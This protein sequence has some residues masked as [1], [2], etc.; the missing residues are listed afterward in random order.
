MAKRIICRN[1]DGVQ[2]EFNYSFEPFFL[3]SV[4]GI[5]TVSNNVV[6]SENTM[7]DGSTY[8][9]S[10]T[11]QRNIVITAQMERDYQAN[12]DL[13][14]K[15]FKPKSTGLFTYMEGNET[16]VI[17]YKV[18][19]IDID[20]AGVV[21]NFSISLLCPDPFFRDLEDISVS[22]ASWTGLF[23]WPH[24]F[25][26]EKEPFA[27]RTAEVLKEIENDSAADNIGITVTLEAE[28]PVINPA[29][30]HAESGEFIKIGNEVRSF[31][32]NAGAW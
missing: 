20:E 13:L 10:T 15:C 16:R 22:M 26:E 21:R 23:E 11:K 5:Y 32:I 29:V 17:D 7:V 18:E 6:T 2:V 28:G 30:Y 25:L 27:E 8:Q 4:D 9:G 3:V 31:S 1:E 12:R 24:E 19:G 14:Y